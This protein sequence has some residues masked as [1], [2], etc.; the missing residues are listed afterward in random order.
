MVMAIKCDAEDDMDAAGIAGYFKQ[1]AL[2][3][4]R[5]RNGL[6]NRLVAPLAYLWSNSIS[7][8]NIVLDCT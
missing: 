7:T 1:L 3:L 5:E 8:V 2:S 6:S 4:T